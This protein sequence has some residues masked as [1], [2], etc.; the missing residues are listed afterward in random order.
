MIFSIQK[1]VAISIQ[2]CYSIFFLINDKHD[3]ILG[4]KTSWKNIKWGRIFFVKYN[5]QN[6]SITEDNQLKCAE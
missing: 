5:V 4:L 3:L 1:L 2:F 6:N